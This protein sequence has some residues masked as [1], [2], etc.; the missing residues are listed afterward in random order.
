MELKRMMRSK[1]TF[2]AH[3]LHSTPD[4]TWLV[5]VEFSFQFHEIRVVRTSGH[6]RRVIPRFCFWWTL[7]LA[8]VY[9]ASVLF[10]WFLLSEVLSVSSLLEVLVEMSL[11]NYVSMRPHIQLH[12]LSIRREGGRKSAWDFS[13]YVADC[14][15]P[16]LEKLELAAFGFPQKVA[17]A[18]LQMSCFFKWCRSLR[19]LDSSEKK[20]ECQ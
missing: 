13:E 3:L 9:E 12:F 2:D 6:R 5:L 20:N 7:A 19:N 18:E 1:I 16:K 14:S 17:E 10:V 8:D 11:Y 4:E 15:L